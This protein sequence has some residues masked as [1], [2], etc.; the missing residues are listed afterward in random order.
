MQIVYLVIFALLG[1]AIGSFLNVAID[2]LPAGRSLAYPP[3]HCDRCQHRLMPGDLIPVFSYLRLH[4]RCRYCRAPIPRRVLWVEL[5]SGV[6]FA[7]TYWHYGLSLQ[8]AIMALYSSLFILL[9]VID[10]ETKR[11]LNRIVYPSILVVLLLN[12]FLVRPGIFYGVAGATCGFIIL[13]LLAIISR[14]GMGWG[15]VKMAAL[16]GLI[17]GFPLVFLALLMAAVI[18]GLVAGCLLLLKVK[19]RGEA[20][21]FGPF[22]SLATM[23]TLFWGSA[24]LDWYRGLL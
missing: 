6:L 11:I 2:R 14:G 5:S 21:P 18:G 3:S 8:F 9:G 20:I 7:L 16:I 23:I 22:L 19:R 13:L 15:D 4:G 24:I 10:L 12:I 1:S 17:V